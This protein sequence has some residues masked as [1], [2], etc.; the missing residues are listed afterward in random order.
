MNELLVE[1]FTITQVQ[2][3][4][5]LQDNRPLTVYCRTQGRD[6]GV[7]NVP[8]GRAFRWTVGVKEIE[9]YH[10]DLSHGNLH[11][12]FDMFDRAYVT[13]QCDDGQCVWR[14]K[15]DGLYLKR[16][17]TYELMFRWP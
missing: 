5:N 16:S 12:H 14:V 7:Q 9:P 6:L 2:V 11:G 10:C 3:I 4:N 1:S 13:G 17:N 8:F 15:S